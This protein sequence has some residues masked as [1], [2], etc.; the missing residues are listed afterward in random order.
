MQLPSASGEASLELR[1]SSEEPVGPD[2]SSKRKVR[3][4][5]GPRR[6]DPDRPPALL[7]QAGDMPDGGLRRDHF[8]ARVCRE[9]QARLADAGV[10]VD[11]FVTVA[12]AIAKE[13]TVAPSG[14]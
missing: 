11:E 6:T 3:L 2:Q 7:Q 4:Q 10:A 5:R 14:V 9:V 8:A 1:P 13:G 12:A